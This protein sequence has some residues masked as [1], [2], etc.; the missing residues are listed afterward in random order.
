[1]GT[2]KV[3]QS[4]ITWHQFQDLMRAIG[5]EMRAND[6]KAKGVIFEAV[7]G[8]A[9]SLQLK[10]P[11]TI[12]YPTYVARDGVTPAFERDYV[13]DL[14]TQMTGNGDEDAILTLIAKRRFDA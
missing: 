2:P 11:V 12:K 1:M 6:P 8:D 10:A 7:E 9:L 5:F 4:P 14:L 13:V 3:A